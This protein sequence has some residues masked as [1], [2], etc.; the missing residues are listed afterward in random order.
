[1]RKRTIPAIVRRILSRLSAAKSQEPDLWIRDDIEIARLTLLHAALGDSG[2]CPP[3][4][5]ASYEV[6]GLHPGKVWPKIL[7]R[8]KA[9]M[10]PLYKELWSE[11][12]KKP[13]RS[14]KLWCEQTN[15]ARAVNSRADVAVLHEPTNSVPMAAPSIAGAY[16]NSDDSGSEKQRPFFTVADIENFFETCPEELLSRRFRHFLRGCWI[17]AGRP[18]G[19]EILLFKANDHYRRACYY[20]SERTVRY[21]R[22]AAEKLN[23]LEIVHSHHGWIR[24]RTERDK[25][26]YRR[27]TTHRLPVSL[28]LRWRNGHHHAVEPTPIRKPA[29]P[30]EK[31]L[32]PAPAAPLPGKKVAEHRTTKRS[33]GR[34]TYRQTKAF[35]DRVNY[36]EKGCQGNVRTQSGE[37]IFVSPDCNEELYRKPLNRAL[38]FKRACEEFDWTVDAA[39]EAMKFHG[40]SLRPGEHEEESG[41]S[42]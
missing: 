24:P 35:K 10:G 32:P 14:V 5:L 29:T 15:G 2:C 39:L 34:H 19:S 20:K 33:A 38:A 37:S 13:P 26:L 9:L 31:P 6:L 7:E 1:M 4:V 40:F 28:L 12:P 17:A 41:A 36:H 23:L 18:F 25:G 8:R 27:V 21:N 22:L 30:S 11:P 42:S 3:H 16:R